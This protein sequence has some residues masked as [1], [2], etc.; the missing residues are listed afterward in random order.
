MRTDSFFSHYRFTARVKIII[1]PEVSVVCD[2]EVISPEL[3]VTK[4][5]GVV[6]PGALKQD[7]ECSFLNVHTRT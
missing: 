3:V 2:S 5:S 6:G 1:P 4:G 7:V